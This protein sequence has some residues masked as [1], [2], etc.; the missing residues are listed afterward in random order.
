[1]IDLFRFKFTPLRIYMERMSKKYAEVDKKK[2]ALK[3]IRQS[4]N[5][6]S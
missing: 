3:R 4:Y 6:N 5:L 2:T 1:V